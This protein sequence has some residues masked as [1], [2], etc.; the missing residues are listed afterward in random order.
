ME[1]NIRHSDDVRDAASDEESYNDFAI[2]YYIYLIFV[3]SEY[4]TLK[5]I[6]SWKPRM[7]M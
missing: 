5:I 1:K 7:V 6:T 4:W 2:L 3:L